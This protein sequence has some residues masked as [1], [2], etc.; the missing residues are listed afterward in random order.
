MPARLI[1]LL[2][3]LSL[4]ACSA[5]EKPAQQQATAPDTIVPA[6]SM[7]QDTAPITAPAVRDTTKPT[8][9]TA[10]VEPEPK[11]YTRPFTDEDF[12]GAATRVK[13]LPPSAFPDLPAPAREWLEKEGYKIPQ[14]WHTEESHNAF[15]GDFF[16]AGTKDW[17]V[18]ASRN[19]ESRIIVFIRG[20]E[21]DTVPNTLEKDIDYLRR[22]GE[23]IEYGR[24]IEMIDS[25]YITE[26]YAKMEN[27]IPITHQGIYVVGKNGSPFALY[28]YEQTWHMLPLHD[29]GD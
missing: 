3:A 20:V 10:A 9:Y 21:P 29:E 13:R 2:L 24:I 16:K 17:A 4:C 14:S 8:E 15:W 25:S 19:L 23:Y 5:G 7:A 1:I 18:L 6:R 27:A 26:Y 11:R 28:S 22:Y 12:M